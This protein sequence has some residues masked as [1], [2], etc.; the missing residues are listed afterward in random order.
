[1]TE[2]TTSLMACLSYRKP[3]E[4][5][6]PP[7]YPDPITLIGTLWSEQFPIKWKTRLIRLGCCKNSCNSGQNL[8]VETI[9]RIKWSLDSMEVLVELISEVGVW[10]CTTWKTARATECIVFFFPSTVSVFRSNALSHDKARKCIAVAEMII[11]LHKNNFTPFKL[12]L[13]LQLYHG[14]GSKHLIETWLIP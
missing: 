7:R 6:G 14:Y 11:S 4:R 3:K 10:S 1:M 8:T 12:G 2:E 13:A 9:D 5:H